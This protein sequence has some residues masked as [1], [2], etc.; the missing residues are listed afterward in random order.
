MSPHTVWPP[1]CIQM[2]G[3]RKAS[4]SVQTRLNVGFLLCSTPQ[5]QILCQQ[6]LLLC[7]C[8]VGCFWSRFFFEWEV[9]LALFACILLRWLSTSILVISMYVSKAASLLLGGIHELGGWNK[10]YAP[11]PSSSS[12]WKNSFSLSRLLQPQPKTAKM[13]RL[14]SVRHAHTY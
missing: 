8:V 2:L 9:V 13:S 6:A 7:Q 12:S 1:L 14:N 10:F 4:D 11:I 3:Q 5:L